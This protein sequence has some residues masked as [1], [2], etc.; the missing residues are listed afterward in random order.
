MSAG[1]LKNTLLFFYISCVVSFVWAAI[2]QKG[3]KQI[4]KQGLKTFF[5]FGFCA[6]ILFGIVHFLS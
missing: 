4:F 2:N 3:L 1:F 5:I 6:V